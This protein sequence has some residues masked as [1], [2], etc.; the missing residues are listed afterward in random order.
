MKTSFSTVPGHPDPIS[1]MVNLTSTVTNS[2]P[3]PADGAPAKESSLA[4]AGKPPSLNCDTGAD[5][6]T[7][8][9]SN[10]MDANDNPTTTPPAVVAQPP[11]SGEKLAPDD[12]G[13]YFGRPAKLDNKYASLYA[14]TFKSIESKHIVTFKAE[15]TTSSEKR[16]AHRRSSSGKKNRAHHETILA[17]QAARNAHAKT[18]AEAADTAYLNKIAK[19][20]PASV[21]LCE[22]AHAVITKVL[23]KRAVQNLREHITV[24]QQ[25]DASAAAFVDAAN[26]PTPAEITLLPTQ[27]EHLHSKVA[28]LYTLS[29]QIIPTLPPWPESVAILTQLNNQLVEHYNQVIPTCEPNV[30]EQADDVAPGCPRDVGSP[31]NQTELASADANHPL[32][33]N[34]PPS[35][36]S[37][38]T[39]TPPVLPATTAENLA[40]PARPTKDSNKRALFEPHYLRHIEVP[41]S[42]GHFSATELQ[43]IGHCEKCPDPTIA[44]LKRLCPSP[45]FNDP[46]HPIV[47]NEM[48]T[49]L[50]L[51]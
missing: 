45:N 33:V 20:T 22:S 24:L 40:T 31:A 49:N 15:P 16:L 41:D 37:T 39:G 47:A 51:G 8:H 18:Q 3:A 26:A 34:S 29:K 30:P 23:C 42:N 50:F 19:Y 5:I 11:F 10:T 9:R 21:Q 48:M 28:E 44:P 25:W 43:G 6:A 12:A 36:I 46:L 35:R 2:N 32:Q 4:E 7:L 1:Y 17:K 38:A 13:P 27:L 14:G